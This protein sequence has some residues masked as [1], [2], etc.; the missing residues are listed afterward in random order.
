MTQD[1]RNSLH[2]ALAVT[3]I[4]VLF[5]TSL[6]LDWLSG[7]PDWVPQVGGLLSIANLIW[8]S[9]QMWTKRDRDTQEVKN[10]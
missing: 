6:R 7:V 2:A 8:L 3:A 10:G 5:A 4:V 1:T 9:W